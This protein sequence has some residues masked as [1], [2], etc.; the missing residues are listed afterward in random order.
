M[1]KGLEGTHLC[2]RNYECNTCN[3]KDVSY[4]D[5]T[6]GKYVDETFDPCEN[7][8]SEDLRWLLAV[9]QTNRWGELG[10]PYFD[11]GLGMTVHSKEHR[12]KEMKKR[13]VVAVGG[14]IDV[15]AELHQIRE[16]HKKEDAEVDRLRTMMENGREYKE[17]QSLQATGWKPEFKTREQSPQ[18]KVTNN[19]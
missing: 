13:G 7:C 6:D 17:L 9:P 19:E 18:P 11:R 1:I 14:D 3:Y 8:G 4:G 12:Q 15:G 2:G 10:F 5:M 16:K